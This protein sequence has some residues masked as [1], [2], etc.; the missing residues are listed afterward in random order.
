[1]TLLTENWVLNATYGYLDAEYDDF[2]GAT[3]TVPQAADPLNNPGCLRE[4]GSNI[5]PGE[6]GGQDLSGETLLFAPKWSANLNATYIQP[7]GNDLELLL[8]VDVNYSDDYYSA[9]D[10]DPSTRH[11]SATLY[12]ARISLSGDDGRWS[13][14]LLGKNLSD[15]VTYAWKNDVPLTASN[16]YF[17]VP[18]RPRSIAIQGRY[19]F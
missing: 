8:G 18:N 12:N 7:L 16:S 15:E 1:M 2:T 17:G 14:S 19:Y 11:D 9:L 5:A 10:L 3:C 4:D 13:I 6:E